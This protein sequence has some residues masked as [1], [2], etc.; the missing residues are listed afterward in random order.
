MKYL[1]FMADVFSYKFKYIYRDAGDLI[2]YHVF[3]KYRG[4]SWYS[5]EI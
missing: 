1:K 2:S 5:N 3:D 4:M